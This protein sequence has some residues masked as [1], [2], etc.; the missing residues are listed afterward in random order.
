MIARALVLLVLL[1]APLRA[2]P[3]P[4]LSGDPV[5]PDTGRAYAILPGVP[6]LLPQSNG[7]YRPPIVD[8]TRIGD[9]D[10]VVRVGHLGIGPAMPQPAA[11]VPV[12]IAGGGHVAEGTEVPFT[13]LVSDGS[14]GLGIPLAGAQMNGIPVIVAAWADLDGD[15]FIGPTSDDAAGATDD[16]R[17][18]Q[19]T[20]LLVGRQVAVLSGGVAEGTIAIW[21]GAPASAG[22]LRI[23]LTALAYVGPFSAGFFEGNLPDG[24]G[25]STMLPFFPRLDPDRI[26]DGEGRGGAASPDGRIDIELEAEF[27][28]P[29]D[30]PQL[31]TPF[32]IPTN[33]T[34]PT[35]DRADIVG[36]PMTRL[37]AVRPSVL[38]GYP[39]EDDTGLARGAGGVLYEPLTS[40][41]VAADGAG[42]GTSVRLVPVDILDNITDPPPGAVATLIAG[43]GLAIG[44]PNL[45]GNPAQEVVPV[46]AA[47]V[48]V[49]LDDAGT[50]GIDTFLDVVADGVPGE[51]LAVRI[52]PGGPGGGDGPIVRGVAVGGAPAALV[53]PCP[54]TKTL[55][56][57]VDGAATVEASLAL[58]DVAVATLSLAS[59]PAP[60]D[61]PL[62]AG[63]VFTAPFLLD[64]PTTG[65][66][67]ATVVGRD[68]LGVAGAPATFQIPVAAAAPPTFGTVT[69]VPEAVEPRGRRPVVV[70]ARVTDDCGLRRVTVEADN[71]RGF[72]RVGRLRDDGRKG[73]AVAGD[74]VFGA[75]IRVRSRA[76]GTTV[77]IRV[78]AKN[79]AR[80]TS[81]SLATELQVVP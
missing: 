48:E 38:A 34:S 26:V 50:G 55:A 58:N 45:D 42:N 51:R 11:V 35:V 19:E 47:G 53:G 70:S 21:R 62:P 32:A 18:L 75:R 61:T 37:R 76:P 3:F 16:D 68:A 73:D 10:L 25:L 40:A 54:A 63:P 56:A 67:I 23:V 20:T 66:L 41:A 71:G 9:V 36:G 74:G 69:L 49:V 77:M 60:A 12:A 24:P 33:G 52:G 39:V 31:G 78:A 30:H 7:R 14:A 79:R 13:V 28:P 57:V 6:L 72:K 2:Q 65:T 29:V 59:G 27:D 1:A 64:G 44:S 17:E 8:P 15:G 4:V 81:R 80:G 43:P 22:G 5:D 46:T